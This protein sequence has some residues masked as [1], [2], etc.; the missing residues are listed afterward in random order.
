MCALTGYTCTYLYNNSHFESSDGHADLKSVSHDSLREAGGP[1]LLHWP[2]HSRHTPLVQV[3]LKLPWG[4]RLTVMW[5]PHDTLGCHMTLTLQSHDTHSTLTWH[6]LNCHMTYIPAKECVAESSS[7]PLD[8]T[9]TNLSLKVGMASIS[10]MASS[11]EG[12]IGEDIMTFC[13]AS[14]DDLRFV[15]S[16]TRECCKSLA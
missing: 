9:A 11:R 8:R 5:Y 4:Q 15:G 6:S 10:T 2:Q 3:G 13:M 1:A 12:G 16:I 14:A 7:V